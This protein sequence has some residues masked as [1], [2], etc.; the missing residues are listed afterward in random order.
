MSFCYIYII[1]YIEIYIIFNEKN[2][3]KFLESYLINRIKFIVENLVCHVL[4]LDL[5]LYTIYI[6]GS[7]KTLA[8]FIIEIENLM[9][10]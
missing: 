3:N 4:N 8:S 1:T 5:F 9:V 2:V 6:V 10:S 7:F